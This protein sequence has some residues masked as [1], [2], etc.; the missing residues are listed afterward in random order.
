MGVRVVGRRCGRSVCRS[1]V[2]AERTVIVSH[3]VSG[4]LVIEVEDGRV[5]AVEAVDVPEG[6]AVDNTA[7]ISEIPPRVYG[8]TIRRGLHEVVQRRVAQL[9]VIAAHEDALVRPAEKLAR[10][11]AA[12]AVAERD[13]RHVAVHVAVRVGRAAVVQRVVGARERRAVARVKVDC[14]VPRA[15]HRRRVNE[16]AAAAARVDSVGIGSRGARSGRGLGAC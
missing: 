3:R 10:D 6:V 5:A 8:P 12:A 13:H 9:V 7:L 14:A 1:V 4:H 11:D 16:Q 15:A 2:R